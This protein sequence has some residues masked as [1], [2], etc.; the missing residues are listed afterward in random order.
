MRRLSGTGFVVPGP[1]AR[2]GDRHGESRRRGALGDH[3]EADSPNEREPGPY[4][5]LSI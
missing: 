5:G 3:A 4:A 2:Y 1:P